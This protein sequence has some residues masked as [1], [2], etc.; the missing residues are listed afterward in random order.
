MSIVSNIMILLTLIVEVLNIIISSMIF[1][2]MDRWNRVRE[3]REKR[4]ESNISD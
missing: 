1:D 2:E 4:N 3:E